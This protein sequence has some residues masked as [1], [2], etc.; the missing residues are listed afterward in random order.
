MINICEPMSY[1]I[2]ALYPLNFASFF[3]MIFELRISN[4][5]RDTPRDKVVIIGFC[6]AYLQ[7]GIKTTEQ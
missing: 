3:S 6:E 7:K 1:K 2:W 5:Q 4:G